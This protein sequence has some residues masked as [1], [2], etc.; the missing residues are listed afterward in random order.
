[1]AQWSADAVK[2]LESRYLR[3]D[4]NLRCIE[5]CDDML[6]RVSAAV[7]ESEKTDKR[8]EWEYKFH[9]VLD[10]LDFLPNS[11]ALFNSGSNRQQLAACFC[12]VPEDSIESIFDSVRLTALIHRSGGGTGITLSKLRGKSTVVNSSGGAA[13]GPVSFMRAFGVCTDIVVQGGRRRGANMGLMDVSHPDILEFIKCKENKIDFASFNI[14]VAIT[15]EFMSSLRNN[16]PFY[17]VDPKTM[18]ETPIDPN[19]IWDSIIYH[20]WSTGEPGLVFMD[21][22]NKYNPIPWVGELEGVN[23][24][25]E[26]VLRN[27]ESCFLG[28]INV[29]HFVDT[30]N[31]SFD[32]RRLAETVEICVRFLDNMVSVSEPPDERIKQAS[33]LTRKIGLGLMGWADALIQLG[34]TYDSHRARCLAYELTGFIM[35]VADDTSRRL[36]VEK[37]AAPCFSRRKNKYRNGTLL[38]IAPTGSISILGDCSNSIEPIFSR[39]YTRKVMDGQLSMSKRYTQECVR[40]ALEI[41]PLDHL[42]MQKAFQCWVDNACSKTI[43]MPDTATISDVADIYK[44]SHEMELKGIT[45]FRQG[46]R[47]DAPIK[48]E[49]GTCSL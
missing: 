22:A 27:F 44:K 6:F 23:P 14:S 49:N 1:M 2:L 47:E 33:S 11:P 8:S 30:K 39:E 35:S 37:G 31:R 13:S 12:I 17:L 40:T 34:I 24:C 29:P 7:A 26:T 25:S 42:K 4:E 5:S 16:T 38:S 41:T 21:T 43:N 45:V 15:T 19:K 9:S 3:K 46:S 28:S 32:Y 48:C 10:K 18:R 36:A 20:A